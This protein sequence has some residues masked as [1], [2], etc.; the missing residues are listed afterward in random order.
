MALSFNTVHECWPQ[1]WIPF[2]AYV[3]L[4]VVA[5]CV[6]AAC[7]RNTPS[8]AADY[9]PQSYT[10]LG[11]MGGGYG[12]VA[13]ANR[14]RRS[15]KSKS[16]CSVE[17]CCCPVVLAGLL[18]TAAGTA[19]AIAVNCAPVSVTFAPL[20][21]VPSV[22]ATDAQQMNATVFLRFETLTGTRNYTIA[23]AGVEVVVGGGGSTSNSSVHWLFP[24]NTTNTTSGVNTTDGT[25]TTNTTSTAILPLINGTHMAHPTAPQ[26]LLFP[27]TAKV[28]FL[29]NGSEV[30]W[31][32]SSHH[33]DSLTAEDLHLTVAQAGTAL[34][35][36]TCGFFGYFC[37]TAQQ[38][39]PWNPQRLAYSPLLRVVTPTDPG[40]P[41]TQ[42]SLVA[43]TTP[44]SVA[45]NATMVCLFFTSEAG[46]ALGTRLQQ[47]QQVTFRFNGSS[48]GVPR[49]ASTLWN[50]T[51]LGVAARTQCVPPNASF[52]KRAEATPNSSF[53][54]LLTA[55]SW[56]DAF[57]VVDV[58]HASATFPAAPPLPPPPAPAA[59]ATRQDR[60]TRGGVRGL[61]ASRASIWDDAHSDG[62]GS[63]SGS[64]SDSGSDSGSGSGSGSDSGD[65]RHKLALKAKKYGWKLLKGIYHDCD[66]SIP[67]FSFD[68]EPTLT[69]S[70]DKPAGDWL[71]RHMEVSWVGPITV[72]FSLQ[73]S[74]TQD[75]TGVE[76]DQPFDLIP[77][78]VLKD[79]EGSI[80]LAEFEIPVIPT[81]DASISLSIPQWQANYQAG[82]QV[83]ASGQLG[84]QASFSLDPFP[85]VQADPIVDTTFHGSTT[86]T[87][88]EQCTNEVS[89]EF[90][91][92]PGLQALYL[93][94]VAVTRGLGVYYKFAPAT[95]AG[96]TCDCFDDGTAQAYEAFG[97]REQV[98]VNFA[99]EM[100]CSHSFTTSL[101]NYPWKQDCVDSSSSSC[102][103]KCPDSCYVDHPVC[104]HHYLALD[105]SLYRSTPNAAAAVRAIAESRRERLQASS[106]ALVTLETMGGAIQQAGEIRGSDVA[107]VHRESSSTP[108][109]HPDLDN[110]HC[111]CS[112][113]MQQDGPDTQYSCWWGGFFGLCATSCSQD[114]DCSGDMI[115]VSAPCYDMS[116]KCSGVQ[117][118]CQYLCVDNGDVAAGQGVDHALE[119]L[120]SVMSVEELLRIMMVPRG[121]ERSRLAA[122]AMAQHLN[123][124]VILSLEPY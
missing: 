114:S 102:Y 37:Q 76:L 82:F 60:A 34:R 71:P 123:R 50:L 65:G 5:F 96:S 15:T 57:S 111:Y 46:V 68:W 48:V 36:E 44:A 116:G 98:N 112:P 109:S 41:V 39:L 99:V 20:P 85:S 106:R 35:V 81:V 16:C 93:F 100:C 88:A 43:A 62:G 72:D 75:V 108:A 23:G 94:D 19:L 30:P 1:W 103:C 14:G 92:G 95:E 110:H 74:C 27:A 51:A 107:A 45:A 56:L 77:D 58:D 73:V 4:V 11:R 117:G 21:T 13:P 115:C 86:M 22:R 91:I 64:G 90:H 54:V 12:T 78:D 10:Q 70:I 101:T 3:A 61:V 32:S 8:S 79:L 25:N 66:V 97:G 67:Q 59:V 119:Q 29:S 104:G 63:G 87:A 18:L 80:K 122:A 6:V 113:K 55:T 124:T 40:P 33:G 2:A 120:G 53:P 69:Y 49:L 84:I 118:S 31:Y 83:T 9:G 7:S 24:I 26:Q 47:G 42:R 28:V 52:A 17:R 105:D 121:L 38:T 89:V